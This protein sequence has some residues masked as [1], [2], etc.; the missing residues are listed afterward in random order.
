MKAVRRLRRP[1]TLQARLT[2]IYG[3]L[4]MLAGLVL[5]GTTYALFSQQINR[6]GAK[7]LARTELRGPGPPPNVYFTIDGKTVT[8]DAA[9]QW[10]RSQQANLQE[11][12]T[13]SLLTF[14]ALALLVVGGAAAGFGWLV[15]GRVL[16]PLNRVT[17]TARRIAAAPA[18]DRGLHERIALHG[19]DDEVKGLADAFD[20]MV[21]RLDRS[22]DGQRRFVANASHELR[23]PLTLGRALVELAMRRA[24]ASADVKRLGEDLLEI[25]SRHERL[26]SGLLVLAGSE[27]EIVQ[28]LPVDL[29]DVVGHVAAQAEVEA[30]ETGVALHEEPGEAPTAGDALLLERL[31]HN[32]V[33]NGIRHNLPHGGW[34][35]VASRVRDRDTVEIEVSNTGPVVPAYEVP[36]LFEPFRRLEGDRTVTGAG[37]GLGLSIVRSVARAHHGDATVRPREGGGLRVIVTLPRADHD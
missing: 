12:A 35:R 8:G 33:E 28:R 3:G 17:D 25:N 20:T 32:L 5:L 29:A 19:P 23:T 9:E 27:R 4:F 10:M 13:T 26:I 16:V 15:A 31:V 18:A 1:I 30:K 34:V 14:G 24:S 6:S 36:S 7:V 21:E 11:A 22:F 37:A 2:L